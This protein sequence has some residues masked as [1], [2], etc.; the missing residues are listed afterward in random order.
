MHQ[1]EE[2]GGAA[3]QACEGPLITVELM[4]SVDV[5]GYL[6]YIFTYTFSNSLFSSRNWFTVMS[7][8]VFIINRKTWQCVIMGV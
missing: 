5:E 1:A 6:Q 7:Y 2:P 3:G 4:P 8:R